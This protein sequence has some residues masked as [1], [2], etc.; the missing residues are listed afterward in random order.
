MT[1][2]PIPAA[3]VIGRYLMYEQIAT[4]GMASI[5][6][7]RLLGAVGFA[8]I[9]AIKHLHSHHADDADFVSMFVDEVRVAARIQHPNVASPLDVVLDGGEIFL[10]MEYIQG[11]TLARLVSSARSAQLVIPAAVTASIVGGALRG[12]H[13]AH[14][15]VDENRKPLNII[16]RDVSPQNIMVGVDGVGRVL[17]FGVAKSM[18]RCQS[19]QQGRLKGKLSYMAPEQMQTGAL[20]RRVDIFA[21]GIVLW[22]ALTHQRLFMFDNLAAGLSM[23]MQARIPRPS[24]IR[25]QVPRT[26]DYVVMRA[27]DRDADARFQTA[28][29]FADAVED[30][31][32]PAT[33]SKVGEWVER[34]CGE[35]LSKRAQVVSNIERSTFDLESIEG[36]RDLLLWQQ[37]PVT[38]SPVT[39]PPPLPDEPST[40]REPPLRA[41]VVVS[42]AHRTNG[43]VMPELSFPVAARRRTWVRRA[44]P[45]MVGVAAVSLLVALAS[46]DLTARA[47]VSPKA[48][49]SAAPRVTSVASLPATVSVS[50]LADSPLPSALEPARPTSIAGTSARKKTGASVKPRGPKPAAVNASKVDGFSLKQDC[51][52]PYTIDARGIRRVKP[53]CP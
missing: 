45:A 47:N 33:P 22:E 49:S 50:A 13:A 36:G 25:S 10:V 3:R 29:D 39:V 35:Q 5:H 2:T 12:L 44:W 48:P 21:A 30:A 9:V 28:R 20:D 16:H 53:Y 46:I 8:R 19:T 6:F 7:G 51:A 27:L 42:A 17:D 24:E 18:Y 34:L 40:T 23:I 43:D 37:A 4:G 52:T 15:A 11:D 41:P 32:L 14:E 31:I 26:L 1:I 38:P